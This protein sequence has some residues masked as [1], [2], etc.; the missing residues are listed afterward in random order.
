VYFYPFFIAEIKPG[1]G[2]GGLSKFIGLFTKREAI[3]ISNRN[4]NR[5]IAVGNADYI[6]CSLCKLHNNRI[7]II[8]HSLKAPV[9]FMFNFFP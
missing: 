6:S 3:Y 8:K 9:Q 7:E 4:K 5:N 2:G 1:E